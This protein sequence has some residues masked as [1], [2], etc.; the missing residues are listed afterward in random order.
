[1][2]HIQQKRFVQFFKGIL[3][4]FFRGKN[5]LE[6]G[7]LNINGTVRDYFDDCF[8]VGLDVGPGP[9][10]DVVCFGE[11][12]GSEANFYDV[13]ISCEC[14]EHNPGYKKTWLNMLRV[15]KPNGLMIMTCATFG[16]KQHGT[17]KTSTVDSPLT[18]GLGQEYYKNLT[19]E[20]FDFVRLDDFF[21]DFFF[22]TDFSCSD[23]Y[24]IGLGGDASNEEILAFKKGKAVALNYYSMIARQ[25]L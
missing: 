9:G 1:M 4:N 14:M 16:R 25:G 5:V 18:V 10:V 22:V 3:P 6:V 19:K 13:V 24:F 20:D 7:S 2:A 21:S 8:H 23:L 11:N 15:M 12:Y 17:T